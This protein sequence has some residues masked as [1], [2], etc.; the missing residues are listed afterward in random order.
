MI[1]CLDC[2]C[3][4]IIG[5]YSGGG[6]GPCSS[7]LEFQ[8]RLYAARN[9]C[10]SEKCGA[11]GRNAPP[12]PRRPLW[13]LSIVQKKYLGDRLGPVRPN[14]FCPSSA[15][16]KFVKGYRLRLMTTPSPLLAFRSPSDGKKFGGYRLGP[17][18]T[19]VIT[20]RAGG[21]SCPFYLKSYKYTHGNNS[22]Y[23]A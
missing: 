14:G 2:T 15:D 8:V 16:K 22:N 5:V 23:T 3:M 4:V 1:R 19:W 12:Q 10:K 18:T 20:S 7:P 17:T 6:I 11:E 21:N 9:A 13:H